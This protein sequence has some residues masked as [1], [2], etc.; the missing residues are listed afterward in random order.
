MLLSTCENICWKRYSDT[1]FL[2]S[3]EEFKHWF[4][5]RDGII[6]SYTIQVS[7]SCC[8]GQIHFLL[9]LTLSINLLPS[10]GL[11]FVFVYICI[12]LFIVS[13]FIDYILFLVIFEFV[14]QNDENKVTGFISFYTLPST[15]M[16]HP[17]HKQLK[18]AYSF[19]NVS[20][21][22]PLLQVMQDALILAK[23]VRLDI[24][25]HDLKWGDMTWSDDFM[26]HDLMGTTWSEVA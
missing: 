1:L 4:L 16:H 11:T 25:W 8:W 2:L 15:V 5:P 7:F 3:Q 20:T 22:A 13:N 17:V 10:F 12:L 26:W 19:Y 6:N 9:Y 14:F 21:D 24:V 23:Q 18:A